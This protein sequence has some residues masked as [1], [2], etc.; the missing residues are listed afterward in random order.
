MHETFNRLI[1]HYGTL[2]ILIVTTIEGEFGPLIGG[3]MARLGKLNLMTLLLA[4]WFG[5]TLSTTTFF[6]IGRSQRDG[7]LVHKVTDKR[8]FA[9]AIKWIDR[10]PRLFCFFYRFVYGL[11]IVGPVAISMSLVR[12]QTFVVINLFSSL[13]WA[14]LGLSVGWYVGPGAAKMVGY[15][16]SERPY[17]AASIVAGALLIGVISWRARRSARRAS[18]AAS[19]DQSPESPNSPASTAD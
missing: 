4:C 15:Y 11:R 10:H 17:L 8:G 1:E 9:L 7:R 14:I 5:A 16:F 18:A 3:A 19:D 6:A 2:G 12:W 13:L